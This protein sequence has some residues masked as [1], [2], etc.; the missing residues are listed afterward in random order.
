M[1][2]FYYLPGVPHVKTSVGQKARSDEP[3]LSTKQMYDGVCGSN[4]DALQSSGSRDDE[5]VS[6]RTIILTMTGI[7]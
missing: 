6:S 2:S 1:F 5:Y 4:R 7:H 3:V